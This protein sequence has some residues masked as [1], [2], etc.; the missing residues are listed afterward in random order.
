MSYDGISMAGPETTRNNGMKIP[1]F[2]VDAFTE[3]IFSGNP[4]AVCPLTHWLEDKQMLAIASE[5]N[6][7]ET[8]FFV[9]ENGA[10][11]LR[12]FSPK[13]EVQLCGHATLATAF[14]IFNVLRP[15]T[16][17]V[18]FHTCSGPLDIKKE[19]DYL[20]M[21]F[22]SLPAR[23]CESVP[24]A[25]LDGLNPSPSVV[26]ES[27]ATAAERNYFVVY[28]NEKDVRDA[29]PDLPILETLHPAGVCITAPGQ[30]SDFVSRYFAPSYGIPEDPVTGSTH[31]SL[32][33]Y[34]SDRLKKSVLRA[35][36]L[37]SR[38]GELLMEPRGPRITLKGKATLY[39]VGEIS[40]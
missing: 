37:S 11:C 2:Q 23:P 38:G 13:S 5:N 39:L 27:G 7:S 33:P 1:L 29:I 16:T 18:R 30:Q 21:D 32:G 22:P 24:K 26:L 25:L 10:Y 14:V 17:S 20:A 19:G 28:D 4:A 36:Q 9:R 34:W 3:N 31:C 15:G 6:L 8:A 12:W 35:Q 40:I